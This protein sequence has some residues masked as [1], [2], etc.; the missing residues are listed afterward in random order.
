MLSPARPFVEEL[1]EHLHTCDNGL[2]GRP[3]PDDLDLLAHLDLALLHLAGHDRA[4]TG[5]GHD[6]LDRH[7]ERPVDGTL[8][9]GDVIVHSV[10]ELEDL[11]RPL[12]VSLER[13]QGTDPHHGDVVAREVVLREQLAYLELDEIE[14]L[15]VVDHV[16]LVERHHDGGHT[17][18]AGEQ[19][20]L[21][22]LWHR[23][24][25]GRHHQDGP[26]H[27]GR[28]G[29]HVLDVVGMP[30]HVD[31]GVVA[32]VGLVLDVGDGDG[33]AALL[34][35]GSLVDLVERGE[36]DVGVL[37]RQDLGDGRRER[38]LAVVDVPHRPDVDVRLRA[39]EL[40]L[41]HD[42]CSGSLISGG[43]PSGAAS[44]PVSLFLGVAWANC[45]AALRGLPRCERL[46]SP[47]ARATIS[48][49][50]ESGTS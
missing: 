20:V 17:H 14:E 12:L 16:R 33:D 5:D 9:L 27:L 15:L 32:L 42:C 41:G 40:L 18:L 3:Q 50:I 26:V 31:V 36:G 13:L 37:L 7:E 43:S 28:A 46:Y 39:L 38:G 6:V 1:A 23:P 47:R 44:L 35:L 49:A 45:V 2:L 8:G 25:G 29:D 4:P 11:G 10:H 30:R 22:G 24:V 19:H 21:A 34:L 48:R